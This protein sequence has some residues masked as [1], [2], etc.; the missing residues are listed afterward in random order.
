MKT[1]F[2]TDVTEGI[3]ICVNLKHFLNGKSPIE[4]TKEGIVVCSNE[5]ND[6]TLFFNLK[7][8]QKR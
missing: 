3:D 7:S 1:H 4:V 5:K 6:H 8:N 2:P